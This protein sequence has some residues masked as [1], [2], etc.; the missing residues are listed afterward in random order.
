MNKSFFT[1]EE[2][3]EL[4][5]LSLGRKETLKQVVNI[6]NV[7]ELR[8]C[9]QNYYMAEF[10]IWNFFRD[11]SLKVTTSEQFWELYREVLKIFGESDFANR[12]G[13]TIERLLM[14]F[15]DFL[16]VQC[17][18]ARQKLHLVQNNA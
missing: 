16:R 12:V 7:N 1:D 18:Q 13:E 8:A 17:R 11:K 5:R 15:R 2:R 14:K 10:E 3:Q 9:Q 6:S 4:F